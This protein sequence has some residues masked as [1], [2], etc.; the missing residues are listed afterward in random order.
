MVRK[1]ILKTTKAFPAIELSAWCEVV[2]VIE[3]PV[4]RKLL[5]SANQAEQKALLYLGA[6]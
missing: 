2:H 5:L 1:W 3:A 6:A 4:G